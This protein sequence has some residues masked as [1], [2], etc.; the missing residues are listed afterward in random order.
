MQLVDFNALATATRVGTFG[1]SPSSGWY[2]ATLNSSGRTNI[3]K[4]GLTQ[5]QKGREADAERV[6]QQEDSRIAEA[7]R[8]GFGRIVVP[9]A[10][11]RRAGGVTGVTD[12]RGAFAAT[13]GEAPRSASGATNDE[14]GV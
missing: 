13:I 1:N 2:T 11:A 7:K 5:V 10:D 12:L 6:K 14:W 9:A 4:S 3:N 8:A